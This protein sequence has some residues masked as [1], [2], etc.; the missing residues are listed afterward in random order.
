MKT[1]SPDELR[2]FLRAGRLVRTM[3]A[4]DFYDSAKAEK[5]YEKLVP[6]ESPPPEGPAGF[7]DFLLKRSAFFANAE[8]EICLDFDGMSSSLGEGE[9]TAD[10]P[11]EYSVVNPFDFPMKTAVYLEVGYWELTKVILYNF[12]VKDGSGK[13]YPSELQRSERGLSVAVPVSLAP[14]EKKILKLISVRQI[15]PSAV[16]QI[17][18][19]AAAFLAALLIKS[20]IR[21]FLFAASPV[22]FS[23][24]KEYAGKL[25]KIRVPSAGKV[26]C[27]L[28]LEYSFPLP[29][30]KRVRINYAFYKSLEK[31][32]FECEYV[33]DNSFSVNELYLKLPL[34]GAEILQETRGVI[35]KRAGKTAAIALYDTCSAEARG[36]FLYLKIYSNSDEGKIFI[37]NS[38]ISAAAFAVEVSDDGEK[39][40]KTLDTIV[41]A[42]RG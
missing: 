39:A 28:R 26:S 42:L 14:K 20:Q 19:H 1:Y 3:L 34:R 30:V 41:T 31:V 27:R 18:R 33:L 35:L 8:Q 11:F 23:G 9:F 37:P 32:D 29:F 21:S 16:S 13:K 2:L 25:Q 17:F 4:Y 7:Q 5:A 24:G 10:R 15:S 6:P 40:M 36:D 38:A 22:I 12:V